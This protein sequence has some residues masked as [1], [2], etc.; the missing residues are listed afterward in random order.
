[1]PGNGGKR[2][3]ETH[4]L[5]ILADITSAAPHAT[6]VGDADALYKEALALGRELSMRPLVATVISVSASCT[7][8]LSGG[9][10]PRNTLLP[11]RPC[12]GEMGM[13]FYLEQME[14]ALKEMA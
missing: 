6:V 3:Q 5:R 13:P 12:S 1:V 4:A 14:P 9:K 2:G 10:R 8:A 7:G 11:S